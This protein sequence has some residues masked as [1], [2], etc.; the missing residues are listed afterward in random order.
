MNGHQNESSASKWGWNGR[1][2]TMC[3]TAQS[4]SAEP[5][6]DILQSFTGNIAPSSRYRWPTEVVQF[7]VYSTRHY[8]RWLPSCTGIENV[9]APSSGDKLLPVPELLIVWHRVQKTRGV[10]FYKRYLQIKLF[11]AENF[12]VRQLGNVRRKSHELTLDQF[13]VKMLETLTVHLTSPSN[14]INYAKNK[15]LKYARVIGHIIPVFTTKHS[16]K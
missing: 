6:A 4:L 7:R 16:Y 5:L 10:F 2:G 8:S 1:N 9:L 12:L 11:T 14:P 3:R 13:I 15:D